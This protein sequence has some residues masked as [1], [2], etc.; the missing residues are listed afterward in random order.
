[1]RSVYAQ[2]LNTLGFGTP[3][4]FRFDADGNP[5]ADASIAASLGSPQIRDVDGDGLDDAVTV[6][7]DGLAVLL[8]TS[9][10]T[11][12]PVAFDTY[13]PPQ[14]AEA[15]IALISKGPLVSDGIL[16]ATLPNAGPGGGAVT[17]VLAS[18]TAGA[19]NAL[20]AVAPGV[21]ILGTHPASVVDSRAD[22][23][24][25][26][27]VFAA[28]TT[29]LVGT[30]VACNVDGSWAQPATPPTATPLLVTNHPIVDGTW[31]LRVDEDEHD[32]LLV[33]TDGFWEVAFGDG[34]GGFSSR[35]VGDPEGMPG[36]TATLRIRLGIGDGQ[37]SDDAFDAFTEGVRRDLTAPLDIAGARKALLPG[38]PKTN[39]LVVA[40]ARAVA[41]TS[42]A[43]AE[44]TKGPAAAADYVLT[45]F[46]PTFRTESWKTARVGD[47]TGDGLPD[48]VA[49]SPNNLDLDF[50]TGTE[51]YLFNASR[52]ETGLPTRAI[53][54]GDFDGDRVN[55]V[56]VAAPSDNGQDDLV[57]AYGRAFSPPEARVT[58][59]TYPPIIQM[60]A[61]N[62]PSSGALPADDLTSD[63]GIVTSRPG[64]GGPQQTVAILR[65][66]GN[67]LPLASLALTK[68][69]QPTAAEP[70]PVTLAGQASAVVA[71][72]ASGGDIRMDVLGAEIVGKDADGDDVAGLRLWTLS[73]L[74]SGGLTR[75]PKPV[76][77]CSV[78]LNRLASTAID[79]NRDGVDEAAFLAICDEGPTLIVFANPGND[80]T[81]ALEPT[82]TLLALPTAPTAVL[83]VAAVAGDVDGDGAPELVLTLSRATSVE[84]EQFLDDIVKRVDPVTAII[85]NR[86]GVLDVANPT[87][88]TPPDGMDQTVN[89]ATFLDIGGKRQLVVATG[90]RLLVVNGSAA[91]LSFSAFPSQ[92]GVTSKRLRS[93]VAG[94][95]TGDGV[96]DLVVGEQPS[97]IR[98]LV[99]K[100]R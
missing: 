23:V 80:A 67:R 10:I 63:L 56:A 28:K 29:S 1:V 53:A 93:L 39:V 48:V 96:E 5:L 100:A 24:C 32:D 82:S 36:K 15:R 87:I 12:S 79:L 73:S 81:T 17:V 88:V 54:L 22:A 71:S 66:S 98:V 85:W 89:A 57:I 3:R 76:A 64:A 11:V 16:L 41:S 52:I 97:T 21:A 2:S 91:A 83:P 86:G 18:D 90:D 25:T 37:T 44:A 45:L 40:G 78:S 43:M 6:G 61:A 13:R 9:P 99:G 26:L 50:F 27:P 49:G 14:G 55:D 38:G 70:K 65:G 42:F 20:A 75:A 68:V 34:K 58:V 46:V 51:S 35:P 30:I 69:E 31:V 84:L 60:I 8:G 19:P 33:T 94:D 47:V 62:L 95:V 72:R 77:G 7:E 92:N 4:V 74:E 59:G